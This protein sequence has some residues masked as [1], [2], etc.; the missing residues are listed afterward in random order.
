MTRVGLR[1]SCPACAVS[2]CAHSLA[3]GRCF[4]RPWVVLT[5]PTNAVLFYQGFTDILGD[6]IIFA[7]TALVVAFF[8]LLV[9]FTWFAMEIST[10]FPERCGWCAACYPDS[11]KGKMHRTMLRGGFYCVIGITGLVICFVRPFDPDV[12]T[13]S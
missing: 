6:D 10:K 11:F 2:V 13:H 12:S 3:R 9:E 8:T 5:P 1:M 7:A 4:R